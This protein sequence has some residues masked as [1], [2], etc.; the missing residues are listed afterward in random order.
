MRNALNAAMVASALALAI[1][2]GTA[3]F[4]GKD[5]FLFD[6]PSGRTVI[7]GWLKPAGNADWKRITFNTN[8]APHDRK[9]INM[10]GY[11][12]CHFDVSVQLND[13]SFVYWWNVNLC[14]T[15]NLVV[16]A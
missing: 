14:Q 6:N 11:G 2:P 13:G 10:A 16:R 15:E 1:L 3:A 8:L 4:A 5:A 12:E 7:A 9:T